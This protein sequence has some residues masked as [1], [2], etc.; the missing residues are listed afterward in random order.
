MRH[1][2]FSILLLAVWVEPPTTI[3]QLNAPNQGSTTIDL[4]NVTDAYVRNMKL[5]RVRL[6]GEDPAILDQMDAVIAQADDLGKFFRSGGT[7][8]KRRK[9]VEQRDALKVKKDL[10]KRDLRELDELK[11]EINELDPEGFFNRARKQYSQTKDEL[12]NQLR[13]LQTADPVLKD[14]IRLIRQHISNYERAFREY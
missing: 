13:L 3:A 11:Q 2:F 4:S 7:A 6:T 12:E 1:V 14:L 8:S 10:R 9:L 5:L